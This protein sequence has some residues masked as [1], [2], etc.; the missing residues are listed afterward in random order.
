M[1]KKRPVG[2]IISSI[3]LLIWGTAITIFMLLL[4]IAFFIP[5]SQFSIKMLANINTAKMHEDFWSVSLHEIPICLA[6]MC[7]G[8][9]AFVAGIG[10]LKFQDWGP[11]LFMLLAIVDILTSIINSIVFKQSLL[12]EA[13]W[14]I[15]NCIVLFYFTRPKVKKQFE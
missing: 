3:F 10:I 12:P 15:F 7:F 11:K 1:K 6:H 2:A 4:T 5:E 13:P 9:C 14:I 8:V